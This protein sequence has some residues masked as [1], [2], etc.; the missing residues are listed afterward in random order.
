MFIKP[1]RSC[2]EIDDSSAGCPPTG[3]ESI[4]LLVGPCT[5]LLGVGLLAKGLLTPIPGWK[6]ETPPGPRD[7]GA[8]S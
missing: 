5:L 4:L 8:G 6:P 7:F 3:I 2:P 1:W